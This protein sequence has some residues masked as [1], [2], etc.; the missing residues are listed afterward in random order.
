MSKDRFTCFSWNSSLP[1]FSGVIVP[2]SVDKAKI[3][4]PFRTHH[5]GNLLGVYNRADY[6]ASVQGHY[7]MYPYSYAMNGVVNFNNIPQAFCL[8]AT[9][10]NAV[11]PSTTK[12]GA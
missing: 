7:A 6:T 12:A 1:D 8:Y 11:E 10:G 5:T 4:V 3:M 9:S 2:N